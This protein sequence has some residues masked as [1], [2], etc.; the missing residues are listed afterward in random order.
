MKAWLFTILRNEFYSQARKNKRIVLDGD[1]TYTDNLRTPAEQHGHLDMKD[2]Q[3]A[4]NELPLTRERQSFL[5]VLLVFL[6]RKL[7]IFVI[8]PW[9]QLKAASI[10]LESA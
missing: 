3:R 2:L 4:L 6:T 7:L 8:V 1:G 10:E 9:A 5:L